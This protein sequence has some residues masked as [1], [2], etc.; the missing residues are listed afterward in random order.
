MFCALDLYNEHC[1]FISE[2]ADV[3]S[4]HVIAYNCHGSIIFI[5]RTQDILLKLLIP[6]LVVAGVCG[7]AARKRAKAATPAI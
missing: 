6:A 2:C 1:M 3:A 5:T 7:L 4:G